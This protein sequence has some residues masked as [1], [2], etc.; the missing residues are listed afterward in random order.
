MEDFVEYVSKYRPEFAS[1]IRGAGNAEIILLERMAGVSLPADYRAFL[2]LMGHADGGLNLTFDGTTDIDEIIDLYQAAA[3]K[4]WL[5][6][7][8][9]LVGVGK[10]ALQAMCL[11]LG[12][13][14]EPPVV[15]AEGKTVT[16]THAESL[17]KL[18]FRTAFMKYRTKALVHRAFGSTASPEPVLKQGRE[19]AG[20]LGYEEMWFSDAVAFCGEKGGA[21]AVVVNQYEGEGVSVV[22]AADDLGEVQR[23]SEAV[24]EFGCEPRAV[25]S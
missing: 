15:L 12:A 22:I 7:D 11:R 14:K 6:P 23:V 1:E 13:G 5:P 9:L 21:A 3:V 19:L 10:L 17:R 16:R 25:Y 2:S 4:D 24:R 20:L 18:L 8:C